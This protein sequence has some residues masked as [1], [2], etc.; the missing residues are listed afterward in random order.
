MAG[1][2][3]HSEQYKVI[4]TRPIR[5][6]GIDKVVGR[7]K[8]GADY[9]APAM[10]H[11]KIL[12]SPHAHARIKSINAERALRMPGV[13]AVIT[14]RDFAPLTGEVEL[15]YGG[16][17]PFDAY[18]YTLNLLAKDSPLPRPCG[19]RRRRRQSPSGRGSP[20]AN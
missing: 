12:R 14:H 7:A 17:T 10:L 15:Q 9:S 11:G 4:G 16:E 20:R 8:Y 19:R 5:H 18:F 6:D 13:R 3:A 2:V 1:P